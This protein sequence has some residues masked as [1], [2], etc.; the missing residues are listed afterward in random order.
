MSWSQ[1]FEKSVHFWICSAFRVQFRFI[2]SH[3]VNKAH[4]WRNSKK[5]RWHNKKCSLA[6]IYKS[7]IFLSS[8]NLSWK[9]VESTW[10]RQNSVD[11][12]FRLWFY[13]YLWPRHVMLHA[14]QYLWRNPTFSKSS[15]SMDNN[16]QFGIVIIGSS[17]LLLMNTCIYKSPY[18]KVR[19]KLNLDCVWTHKVTALANNWRS[20]F[21]AA[22]PLS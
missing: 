13:A 21:L 16:W 20:T 18:S 14:R 22:L 2:F 5:L 8:D 6:F 12:M 1:G 15:G 3:C 17:V 11:Q 19:P 7:I 4:V 10:K 9:F